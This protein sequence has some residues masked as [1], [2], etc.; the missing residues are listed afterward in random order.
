MPNALRAALVGVAIVCASQ[1]ATAGFSLLATGTLNGS[2]AGANADLSGLTG[3]LEDGSAKNLLGGLGSGLTWDGGMN[4]LAVPDRGPNASSYSTAVDNTTSYIPRVHSISMQLTPNAPG[5]AQPFTLLSTLNATTLLYSATALNYGSGIGLGAGGANLPAGNAVN[6]IAGAYFFSGRSDNYGTGNSGNAA[7]A[8][9]DPEAIRVSNDGTK[10]Y[11]SDEYGPYVR[12]FDR[13]TGLLLRTFTMPTSFDVT[14]QSPVGTTEISG[15]TVGRTANKGMEGLAITPDGKTL[16]GML[17]AATIQDNA[18]GG[19]AA[20][21]LRIVTIDIASGNVTGQFAYNLTTGSGVSELVAL[22]ATEFL[23][24][25]RD[26]KGLG[27]GTNA[28][29]KQVFKISL[30]GATDVSSMNG[31]QAAANAV[32]KTLFLDL[33]TLLNGAPNS[34]A[35]SQIP[36]KIEGMAIGQDVLVNSVLT[37]TLWIANDN[38]FVSGT[39]GPNRFYVVGFI[40]ADLGGSALVQQAIPLPASAALFGSGLL[41]LIGV[42]FRR[43]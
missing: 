28:A 2:S 24:D 5:S 30:A 42:R 35:K 23:V 4:F 7:N 37:H 18:L 6:T 1:P 9:F 40:D 32:S 20:K 19:A 38:D 12:E 16:V 43:R 8:R 36:A 33:V 26:G 29:I 41:G 11:I 25:E 34:I 15:N 10:V 21:V 22:N 13:A 39:A 27:D 3:T 17:Q 14:N 31:T